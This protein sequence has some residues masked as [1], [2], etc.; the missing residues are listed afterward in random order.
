MHSFINDL[1]KELD[2]LVFHLGVTPFLTYLRCRF[3]LTSMEATAFG[4]RVFLK[5]QIQ[6]TAQTTI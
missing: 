5:T 1:L 3:A 6:L 2:S 4:G